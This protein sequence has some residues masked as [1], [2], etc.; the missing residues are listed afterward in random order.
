MLHHH[1]HA[2]GVD[3]NPG[4]SWEEDELKHKQRMQKITDEYNDEVGSV[5]KDHITFCYY[6]SL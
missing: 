6:D 5:V 2:G 1:S 4:E 3:K